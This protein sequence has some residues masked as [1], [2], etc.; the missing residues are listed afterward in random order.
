MR[1]EHAGERW[2]KNDRGGIPAEPASRTLDRVAGGDLSALAEVY[3][4]YG[5]GAYLLAH[6]ITGS[7]SDAQDVVQDL[8]IALPE[9]LASFR[10]EGSFRAWFRTCTARQALMHLRTRRRRREIDLDPEWLPAGRPPLALERID[11]ETA[12]ARLP[13]SLRVVVVL[14]DIEGFSHDDIAG[15]LGISPAA[16]R[17]RLMRARKQLR[18]LVS[19]PK[20]PGA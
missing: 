19:P 2:P 5:H 1:P 16:S 15:M 13:D 6:Q 20:D 9:A 10:G 18:R 7:R 3:E 17:M 4:S 12:L 14:R 11:L 8:F